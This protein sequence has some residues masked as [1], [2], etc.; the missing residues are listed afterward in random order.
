[1]KEITILKF[2]VLISVLGIFSLMIISELSS[3]ELRDISSITKEDLETKVKI[4]GKLISIQE[5]PGLY[6][7]TVTDFT[8]TIPII[9]F[10]EESL[11]LRKNSQVEIE[12]KVAE[13]EKKLE[14]IADTIRY[15]N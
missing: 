7:L 2:S 4:Q 13:Y 15:I 5:T 12:G 14:I 10:K 9:V 8:S 11:D 1:M 3:I 6:I